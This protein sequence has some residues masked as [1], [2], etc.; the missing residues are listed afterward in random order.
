MVVETGRVEALA[1]VSPKHDRASF[2]VGG[3]ADG[4]DDT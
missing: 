2:T 3:G 1:R 4:G